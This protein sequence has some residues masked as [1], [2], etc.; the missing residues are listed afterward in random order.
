MTEQEQQLQ[1]QIIGLQID[2]V[3][4]EKQIR[5][6]SSVIL[7]MQQDM[8]RLNRELKQ[9]KERLAAPSEEGMF[10]LAEEKPPHY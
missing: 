7:K 3:D 8:T 2:L 9:V 1:D 10:N 4:Q 6:L 5:E